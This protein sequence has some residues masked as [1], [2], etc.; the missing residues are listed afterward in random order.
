MLEAEST[1]ETDS[2]SSFSSEDTTLQSEE[3]EEDVYRFTKFK[4]LPLPPDTTGVK[5]KPRSGHRIVYYNGRVYSFGG[6]NPAID[7]ADPEMDAVWEES[8]PLLKELWELNLCTGRWRKCQMAGAVPDQLASHTAVMH[9]LKPGL[10]LIYGGTGAPFGITTSNTMV[11]CDLDTQ[12]FSQLSV[13]E[14]EDNLPPPL[15]GQAVITDSAGLLY[16]VGGT[17]GFTYFMD[18]HRL[19]LSGDG[20][21]HWT[22]LYQPSGAGGEP[23]PRYRHEL[24]LWEDQLIVLGGGTSFSADTFQSLPTFSLASHSWSRTQTRPDPGCVRIDLSEEGWPDRRRCHSAVQRGENVWIFGGYDGEEIFGDIWHLHLPSMQ[25]RRLELQLPLPVYF[26]AMTLSQ[27]GRM[28]MFGGVD[29]IEAN[30]RTS[31]VFS[32]WLQIPSLKVLA[33]EA[34]CHRRGAHL[35]SLPAS[36]LVE[37]G[38]PR[39]CVDMLGQSQSELSDRHWSEA[40][41][42]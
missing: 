24:C 4:F 12:H 26:H 6:Y 2:D 11:A 7:P 21:P 41:C 33:W 17:S 18:V 39:D 30:T 3:E 13:V 16:T 36:L 8:R 23:E 15:Y 32:C 25:W 5:P 38:V 40:E 20:P 35:G 1:E 14:D 42:G 34:V 19:D 29:D 9:P 37:E 31:Q 22:C 28:V 10:M 27:E